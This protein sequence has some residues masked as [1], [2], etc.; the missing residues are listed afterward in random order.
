MRKVLR[1]VCKVMLGKDDAEKAM[2]GNYAYVAW[3]RMPY[4][5]DLDGHPLM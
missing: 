2:L 3:E 1:E 5:G 4:R